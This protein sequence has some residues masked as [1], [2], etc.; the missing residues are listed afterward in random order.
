MSCKSHEIEYH[1]FSYYDKPK[2]YHNLDSDSSNYND[3]LKYQESELLEL[4]TEKADAEKIYNVLLKEN[5]LFAIAVYTYQENNRVSFE[6]ARFMIKG[7]NRYVVGLN[8][9][10]KVP[11]EF[12][13]SK[14]YSKLDNK[15]KIEYILQ[16]AKKNFD[17]S[18]G[19]NKVQ[20]YGFPI[21]VPDARNGEIEE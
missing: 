10:Y 13:N 17:Y 14:D 12:E 20:R 5:R 18:Y 15:K 19:F 21:P 2:F 11:I 1:V 16:L 7:K 9:Y 3:S 4:L 6:S 8:I